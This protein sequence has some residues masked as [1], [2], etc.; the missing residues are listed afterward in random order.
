[1][2]GGSDVDRA[3]Q[4]RQRAFPACFCT[5]IGDDCV[6]QS[7]YSEA[8]SESGQACQMLIFVNCLAVGTVSRTPNAPQILRSD[9]LRGRQRVNDRFGGP[10]AKRYTLIVRF[11]PHPGRLIL[12][13]ER[14][15]LGKR[16][17][18]RS[19]RFEGAKQSPQRCRAANMVASLFGRKLVTFF[20]VRPP[21]AREEAAVS[22]M[23][24]GQTPPLRAAGWLAGN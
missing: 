6:R 7:G 5:R 2:G 10:S 13:Q 22:P 20:G 24:P 4:C 21:L 12:L 3:E 15:L 18:A 11:P 16:L 8:Y 9:Q 14:L 17:Q 1:M 19:Y 23:A